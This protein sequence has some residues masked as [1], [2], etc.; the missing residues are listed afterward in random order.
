VIPGSSILDEVNAL[1]R[2]LLDGFFDQLEQL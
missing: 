2:A 1:G